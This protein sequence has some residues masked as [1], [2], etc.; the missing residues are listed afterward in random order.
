MESPFAM[1][2]PKGLGFEKPEVS[3]KYRQYAEFALYRLPP[4]LDKH[5][6]SRLCDD[7]KIS[8]NT[9][10]HKRNNSIVTGTA[11]ILMNACKTVSFSHN[12]EKKTYKKD[13]W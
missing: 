8:T 2:P 12:V 7:Y 3:Y 6:S 11:G 1:F 4:M 10:K 9:R 13:A 5:S